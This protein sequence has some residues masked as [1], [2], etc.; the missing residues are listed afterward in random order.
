M[1]HPRRA[2]SSFAPSARASAKK[3]KTLKHIFPLRGT[4]FRLVALHRPKRNPKRTQR[5]QQCV[6]VL[7]VTSLF[8]CFSRRRHRSGCLSR[9]QT[10]APKPNNNTKPTPRCTRR[11]CTF[12]VMPVTRRQQ[13]ATQTRKTNDKNKLTNNFMSTC[14]IS[15]PPSRSLSGLCQAVPKKLCRKSAHGVGAVAGVGAGVGSWV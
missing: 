11:A 2:G 6:V 10:S 3:T 8:R 5:A 15:L 7:L 4:W 13:K 14:L 12:I 9:R 1:L